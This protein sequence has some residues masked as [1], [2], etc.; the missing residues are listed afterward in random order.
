MVVLSHHLT[1]STSSRKNWNMSKEILVLPETDQKD[2]N[3]EFHRSKQRWEKKNRPKNKKLPTTYIVSIRR[4]FFDNYNTDANNIN[5]F[6]TIKSKA[7]IL[8]H[9]RIRAHFHWNCWILFKKIICNTIF[10]M[11]FY[12]NLIGWAWVRYMYYV[13]IILI[14]IIDRQ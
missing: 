1:S 4:D 8:Q 13:C 9:R 6:L 2:K 7:I 14:H 12:L 10:C 3:V 11:D 5:I